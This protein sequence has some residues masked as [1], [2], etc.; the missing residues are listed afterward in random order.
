MPKGQYSR[1]ATPDRRKFEAQKKE[2]EIRN[3]YIHAKAT[4]QSTDTKGRYEIRKR[5]DQ[6]ALARARSSN[7]RARIKERARAKRNKGTK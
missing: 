7:P 3:K 5:R 6:K 2:P 1:A 4:G